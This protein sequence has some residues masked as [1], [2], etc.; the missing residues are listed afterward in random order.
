MGLFESKSTY[1]LHWQLEAPLKAKHLHITVAIVGLFQSRVLP[2]CNCGWWPHWKQISCT[3]Q[4]LA[5]LKAEYLHIIVA[6]EGLSKS[7]AHPA[8]GGPAMHSCGCWGPFD[9]VLIYDLLWSIFY[10]RVKFTH[11]T[12]W[13]GPQKEGVR[14]VSYS[15]LLKSITGWKL[16]A[17]LGYGTVQ[18]KRSW[19]WRFGI[20][21]KISNV[22]DAQN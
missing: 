1:I 7:I 18:K 2:H 6:V 11:E 22:D 5:I 21:L 9:R 20:S 10:E 14:Q 16:R 4:L 3:L 15:P 8:V 13:E 17:T 19:S 12:P